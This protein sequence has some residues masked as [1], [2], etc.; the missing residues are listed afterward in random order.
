MKFRFFVLFT[1]WA[2]AAFCQSPQTV[3]VK[4]KVAPGDP[5]T[6][7]TVM[8]EIESPSSEPDF[9]NLFETLTDSAKI[10]SQNMLDHARILKETM[11]QADFISTLSAQ[12]DGVIEIIMS[13]RPKNNADSL[14]TNPPGNAMEKMMRSMQ[15]GVMLRG[16]VYDTGGIHSFWI[17]SRQ[18]I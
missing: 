3:D 2:S 14:D 15:Q 12:Q 11:A 17:K 10:V 8:Q 13:T 18:K 16:S 6:Y 1:I 7:A 5:L 9:Q 4:W